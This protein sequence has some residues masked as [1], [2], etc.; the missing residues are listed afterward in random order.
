MATFFMTFVKI[1]SKILVDWLTEDIHNNNINHDITD[2][3]IVTVD[4]DSK[5]K[6]ASQPMLNKQAR[7]FAII[8]I[9][10][11]FKAYRASECWELRK[12]IMMCILAFL[13]YYPEDLICKIFEVCIHN[14]FKIIVFFYLLIMF[15]L[16]LLTYT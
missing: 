14:L 6:T 5:G 8:I 12:L 3:K 16:F 9:P 10:S 1:L 7:L 2:K 4:S 15:F 13:I 11:L